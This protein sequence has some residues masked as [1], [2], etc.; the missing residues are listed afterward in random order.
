MV[1]SIVI[2]VPITLPAM[3]NRG[4]TGNALSLKVIPEKCVPQESRHTRPR[5]LT[6]LLSLG[7][8]ID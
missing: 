4:G 6:F 2:S 3:I 8:P 7:W 5:A 1:Q